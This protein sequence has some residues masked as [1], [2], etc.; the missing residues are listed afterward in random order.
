MSSWP[1][2]RIRDLCE[3]RPQKAEARRRL[4]LNDR[5]SFVP[6]NDLP[7]NAIWLEA[8]G[9][10]TLA[11]V[12]GSYTYFADGDVLLA[13]IT[14]CFEN[15]KLGVARDL[16][17]GIGFGSSEFFVL[18]PSDRLLPQYLYYYLSRQTFRGR[19]AAVMTGA[20]GHRRVPKEFIEDTL[21]PLPPLPEQK[22]IVAILDE[23]FEGIATATANAERNLANAQELFDATLR[24]CIGAA[25]QNAPTSTLAE[26]AKQFG[27]GKSKH[28]PRNDPSLYGGP[29]P[30][31]QTGDVRNAGH[32]I[33]SHSQT[34]SEAGLRQSKLWPSGTICITIAANI[35]ETGILAFDACFPDSVIGVVVDERIANRDYVEFLLQYFRVQLKAQ[36]KGSAQDNI[37]LGTFEGTQFPFPQLSVQDDIVN[38]LSMLDGQSHKL[39]VSY[40]TKLRALSELKQS[41]L[42]KAFS[43]EFSAKEAVAART[44]VAVK[45]THTPEFSADILA[46]AYSKHAAARREKTLG[47]VKGQKIL[48]LVESLANVDLG[49][50]P[51]KDVAGPNDSAHMRRAEQWAVEKE[52]FT[53][54]QRDGGGYDFKKGRAFDRLFAG[55]HARLASHRD[56]IARLIEIVVPMDSEQAEVLATVHAAW[57]NLLIDGIEPTREAILQEA[58]QNWTPSKLG[59]A[60][61]KFDNAIRFIRKN[62][63][64]PDGSAKPVRAKQESLF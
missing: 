42:Q 21:I 55:V 36:G 8:Q 58:R 1:L 17:N 20:V 19:G 50:E 59:I 49:R 53:F 7:V 22:R 27:R 5:V 60:E 56:A 31:I 14:P 38:R 16:M 37:N 13:K 63:L 39:K 64:I 47:R 12:E 29:Y 32:Y 43:G 40:E 3:L 51:I 10:R 54:V 23:A 18:R 30:F 28:R 11:D 26:I 62:N 48:H 35:A 9:T 61:S 15:G 2:V 57:N 25:N 6:M 34:Y 52:Y 44:K 4:K 24:A 33:T 41:I 45:D 46:F